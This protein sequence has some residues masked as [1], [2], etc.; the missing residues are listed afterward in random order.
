[1]R[2]TPAILTLTIAASLLSVAPSTAAAATCGE[3]WAD[4]ADNVIVYGEHTVPYLFFPNR[5]E[6]GVCWLADDG[7]WHFEV[8]DD[9]DHATPEDDRFVIHAL[10][11]D[12]IVVPAVREDTS[13]DF[14]CPDYAQFS[15]SQFPIL[16]PMY[17]LPLDGN[18]DYAD[19]VNRYGGC[20]SVLEF[21]VEVLGGTGADELHGTPGDDYLVSNREDEWCFPPPWSHVCFPAEYPGDD[22]SDVLCGY[23]GD[24]ELYAD[25]A[26]TRPTAVCMD[27][28]LPR[29]GTPGLQPIDHC[30]GS[31]ANVDRMN[32]DTCT[33]SV[34]AVDLE[35]TN[36]S[37]SPDACCWTSSSPGCAPHWSAQT[38]ECVCDADP[39]CCN[40]N[41][42]GLCVSEVSSVCGES[43][44]GDYYNGCYDIC[45]H[46]IGG[47]A[48]GDVFIGPPIQRILE[49]RVGPDWVLLFRSPVI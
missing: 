47:S 31:N 46:E 49:D 30:E 26:I 14:Q 19:C 33:T 39:W 16:R 28:G 32:A 12:D 21:G 11:G 24:D 42:D 40:N 22:A 44:S 38:E 10:G 48:P 6:L 27:G 34:Q 1:M 4:N 3:L 29:E 18:L 43:C 25:D 2:K 20:T 41:W 13:L 8:F 37:L 9:C 15:P 45:Q 36:D 5:R 35:E 23:G 7:A 17:G